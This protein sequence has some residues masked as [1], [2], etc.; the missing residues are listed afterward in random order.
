M[1]DK[2]G[3]KRER[4]PSAEGSLLPNDAKTPPPAASRSPPLSG[5]P[6]KVSSHRRCSPV[7]EQ[8]SAS[9]MAPLSGPAPL[10]IDTS[11][12]EKFARK[13]FGDLNCDIL[14]PPG[15]DKIIIID[16]S[17]DDDEAQ[18]E[19]AG[20]DP[21]VVPAPTANAP[22]GAE[23]NNSDDQGSDQEADSGYDSGRSTSDP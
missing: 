12:D 19:T 4:S 21:T 15:D 2:R 18:E 22:A 10:V 14:G 20:I 8:G 13:L 3:V 6:S 7:F 11:R 16:D 17:D 23:V 9:G 5:S 1:E